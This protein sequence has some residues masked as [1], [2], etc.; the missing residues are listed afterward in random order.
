MSGLKRFRYWLLALFLLAFAAAVLL[1]KSILLVESSSIRPAQIVVILGSGEEEPAARA[2]ELLRKGSAPR[3][4]ISGVENQSLRARLREAKIPDARIVLE[5][6]ST[7]TKEHAEFTA[8]LLRTQKITNAIVVTSWF[9][10]RRALA[11]FHKAAPEI[12]FQSA[13]SKPNVTQFGIPTPKDA[14][15][16]AAEYLKIIWYAARWQIFPWDA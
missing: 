11:C 16:A 12:H 1:A 6:K 9:R 2:L 8:E 3:L 15:Y 13:P 7:S 14:A 10:S 4:L 5:S